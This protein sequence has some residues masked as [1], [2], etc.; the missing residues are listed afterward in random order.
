MRN[1]T[2]KKRLVVSGLTPDGRIVC[3]RVRHWRTGK[4]IYPVEKKA[5]SFIPKPKKSTA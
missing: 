1:K 5:L 2:T 4:W 3:S